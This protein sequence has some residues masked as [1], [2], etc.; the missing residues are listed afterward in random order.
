M[1][2][3]APDAIPA[4]LSFTKRARKQFDEGVRGNRPL[5]RRAALVVFL[6]LTVT[7]PQLLRT[8]PVPVAPVAGTPV[9][10]QQWG[11]AYISFTLPDDWEIDDFGINVFA[12]G[13]TDDERIL[14]SSIDQTTLSDLDEML[15]RRSECPGARK[16]PAVVISGQPAETIDC[17]GQGRQ[18]RLFDWRMKQRLTEV[19]Y[20]ASTAPEQSEA[21]QLFLAKLIVHIDPTSRGAMNGSAADGPR[22]AGPGFALY[23][24]SGFKLVKNGTAKAA[25]AAGFPPPFPDDSILGVFTSADGD[26]LLAAYHPNPAWLHPIFHT[27]DRSDAADAADHIADPPMAVDAKGWLSYVFE[28]E[29]PNGYPG[30]VFVTRKGEGF[31]T[32]WVL[33]STRD[34]AWE[35]LLAVINSLS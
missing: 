22:V 6:L 15:R 25:E 35:E 29:D 18:Y 31:L 14:V 8:S 19:T 32:L 27:W 1:P 12:H 30:F 20:S 28:D 24:P 23:A 7:L 21:L 5:Q 17:A 13:P 3:R 26:S 33:S 2:A 10:G 11:N 34:K 4:P 16:R 9:A